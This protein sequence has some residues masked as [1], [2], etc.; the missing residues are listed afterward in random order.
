[1]SD[2]NLKEKKKKNLIQNRPGYFPTLEQ[3]S[4][5]IWKIDI[6]LYILYISAAWK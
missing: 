4:L 3:F 2:I 6:L 5:N 1:M